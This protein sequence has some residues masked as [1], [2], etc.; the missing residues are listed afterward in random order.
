MQTPDEQRTTIEA[1][2]KIAFSNE[3]TTLQALR[4]ILSEI[5]S[6]P[7]IY[8]FHTPLPWKLVLIDGKVITGTS[9]NLLEGVKNIQAQ[10]ATLPDQKLE[11]VVTLS[12]DMTRHQDAALKNRLNSGAE[13]A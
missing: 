4:S 7:G 13:R 12:I 10:L 8:S 2:V 6:A 1:L 11:T 9:F 5:E 3:P